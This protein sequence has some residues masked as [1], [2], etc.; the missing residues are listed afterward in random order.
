MRSYSLG[1]A[2]TARWSM[3]IRAPLLRTVAARN[4]TEVRVEVH[5]A[6]APLAQADLP[7]GQQPLTQQAAHR[8]EIQSEDA[9]GVLRREDLVGL[10]VDP[11]N[12]TVLRETAHYSVRQP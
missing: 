7:P 12:A 11:F 1:P 2:P 3:A 5:P 10:H 9:R 8:L 4:A 6:D